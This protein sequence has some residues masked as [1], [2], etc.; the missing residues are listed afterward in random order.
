MDSLF[1]TLG[2]ACGEKAVCIILSGGG[3]DGSEGLK[4]VKESGGLTIAQAEFDH[5]ALSGMPRSAAATG[6]VDHVLPVHEVPAKLIAYVRH[7]QGVQSDRRV[8][9]ERALD[10]TE[11]LSKVCALVRGATGHDFS[12]YKEKLLVRRIQ[13]RM[14]VLQL[15]SM[16]AYIEQSA[17]GP[18]R[19]RSSLPRSADRRHALLSRSCCLRSPESKVIEPLLRGM[20]AED[21]VRVWVP[22]HAQL[23]R[24]PT[25]SATP[26]K[27]ATARRGRGKE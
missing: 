9:M 2:E 5:H 6:L 14:Q 1:S 23:A 12:H 22:A 20:T 8:R 24:K 27:A 3:N 18:A 19:S 11:H 17:Q 4:V 25:R 15:D 10:A 16:P 21:T 7:L 13:R 26:G